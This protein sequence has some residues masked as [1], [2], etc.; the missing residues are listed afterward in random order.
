MKREKLKGQLLLKKNNFHLSLKDN[1]LLAQTS[2][3]LVWA[4]CLSL[5]D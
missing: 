3:L 2:H 4:F 5:L 1:H